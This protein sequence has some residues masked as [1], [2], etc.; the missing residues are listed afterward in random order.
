M[1]TVC[2]TLPSSRDLGRVPSLP[3]WITLPLFLLP[4]D[5][6]VKFMDLTVPQYVEKEYDWVMSLEVGE[7]IPKVYESIFIGNI[8]R[9]A[10]EGVLLSWGL[11]G[12]GGHHHVNGQT[13]EY[14]AGVMKALGWTYDKSATNDL[15][16]VASLPHFQR[17]VMVYRR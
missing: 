3:R 17:T 11:P 5:S 2:L 10:K 13:N 4:A 8:V 14:L 9:H 12:Q 16:A 7:H 15:A 1:W 6:Y